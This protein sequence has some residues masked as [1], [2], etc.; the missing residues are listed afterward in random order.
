MNLSKIQLGLFI[1]RYKEIPDAANKTYMG[2]YLIRGHWAFKTVVILTCCIYDK[3]VLERKK[4]P[5]GTYVELQDI[6][7]KKS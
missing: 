7:R 4:D 3:F 5:C 2:E 6:A 1:C